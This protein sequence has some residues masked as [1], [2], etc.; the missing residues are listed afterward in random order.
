M[1]LSF[2]KE[3]P[4]VL[5]IANKTSQLS[6]YGLFAWPEISLEASLA[7]GCPEIGVKGFNSCSEGGSV[8][9]SWIHLYFA[10]EVKRLVVDLNEFKLSPNF[11]Y[12]VT[13]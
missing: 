9:S 3:N 11:L 10:K 4:N 8:L 7:T 5:N 2:G 1:T 12:G 6:F 13:I